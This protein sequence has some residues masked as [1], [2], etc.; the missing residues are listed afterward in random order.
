MST[1]DTQTQT[2]AVDGTRLRQVMARFATGVAI[3]ATIED[4]QPFAAA[5]NS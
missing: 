2:A 4:E 3:V 1:T 5:V